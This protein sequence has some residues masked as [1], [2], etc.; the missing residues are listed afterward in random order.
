[1]TTEKQKIYYKNFDVHRLIVSYILNF[2]FK[3]IFIIKLIFD[4]N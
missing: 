4:L 3:N 2:I 1:M